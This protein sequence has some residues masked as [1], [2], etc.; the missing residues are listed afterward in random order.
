MDISKLP[1]TEFENQQELDAALK[2]LYVEDVN[3]YVRQ[4]GDNQQFRF[5]PKSQWIFLRD[6]IQEAGNFGQDYFFQDMWAAREIYRSGVKHV[7]DIGSRLDG[8]ISH[9]LS[10]EVT[11][12][13]L[14]IR[15]FKHNIDGL[16]FIQ[17]DA[18][19][20]ENIPDDSMETVSALC[21]FEHFGLGRYGDP[22]DYDGWKKA[23]RAVK[24]KL[25][26]GGNFY[27]AV[28]VGREEKLVF[29]AHRIFNPMTIINEMAPEL[30]L[31]EFSCVAN[32]KIYTLFKGGG[33]VAA[34]KS[35][36]DSRLVG[37]YVTGL[38]TFRKPLA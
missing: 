19:N 3:E 16:N 36:V 32:W 29:N 18:M 11:V 17:T 15:P 13:M 30:I 28:P 23:L 25:K 1:K 31:H 2:N 33:D 35:I 8:Y 38:F 5:S 26:V 24:R 21:S 22:I 34:L 6:C 27:L 7:Y 14:D 4:C 9:L 20:M 37:D 10:M 12:T